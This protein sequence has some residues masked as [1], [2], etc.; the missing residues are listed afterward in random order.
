MRDV[1]AMIRVI[2]REQRE[3]ERAERR[4]AAHAASRQ[5]SGR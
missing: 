5:M 4:R 2:E 1:Q 3:R